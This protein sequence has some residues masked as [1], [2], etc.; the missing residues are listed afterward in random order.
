MLKIQ[1]NLNK[2]I[3]ATVTETEDLMYVPA[4]KKRTEQ[5]RGR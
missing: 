5:C 4:K 1:Q 3:S 2:G